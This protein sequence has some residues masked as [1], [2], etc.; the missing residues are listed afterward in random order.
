MPRGL[1]AAVAQKRGMLLCLDYDGTLAEIVP[2]RMEARPY[3]GIN[4]TLGRLSE[5]SDRLRLAVITGRRIAEV[6]ALLGV[7]P[8]LLYSGVHGLELDGEDKLGRLGSQARE[9]EEELSKARC[10]LADNVNL[11]RGFAV[12][13]KELALALHYR[14]AS[15]SEA[16]PLCG[17]LEKFVTQNLA[18]LKVM[19]L[20]MVLEVLPTIASKWHAVGELRRQVNPHWAVTYIGDDETDED[21]FVR[22][23]G[24]DL[25]VVVGSHRPSFARYRL[26]SPAMVAD[27]LRL[28]A[29]AIS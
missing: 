11:E 18:Q 1:L 7:V 20:K 13:D 2:E 9:Y 8:G 23:D 26:N 4:E 10:W 28:L 25:G 22:M 3:P 5:R 19:R 27:E 12:E 16:A 17:R 6:R 29:D 14:L 15:P 24:T 21:V